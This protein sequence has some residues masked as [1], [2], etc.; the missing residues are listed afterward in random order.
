VQSGE[1]TVAPELERPMG[2]LELAV[3][4]VVTQSGLVEDD[5]VLFRFLRQRQDVLADLV[6]FM[7]RDLFGEQA[8]D[9]VFDELGEKVGRFMRKCM[10][11][12]AGQSAE[13]QSA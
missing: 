11:P 7:N 12:K 9:A 5:D 4:M 3:A 2:E 6:Q 13:P 8:C 10:F 1:I